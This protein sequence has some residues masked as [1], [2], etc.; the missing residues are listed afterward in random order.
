MP[1]EMFYKENTLLAASGQ[2][3][4]GGRKDIN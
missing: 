2:T 1:R 4:N 3:G